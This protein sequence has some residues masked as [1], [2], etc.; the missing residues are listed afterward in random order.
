MTDHSSVNFLLP[1]VTLLGAAVVAVPLFRRFK[2][3]SV[4]GYLVAGL[5]IGPQVFGLFH[6]P[7]TI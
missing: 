5:L 7:Q 6:D 2:L 1:A 4:V 3:G